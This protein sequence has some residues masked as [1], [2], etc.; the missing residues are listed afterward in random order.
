MRWQPI[1][2]AISFV[3]N[4]MNT[5]QKIRQ[6]IIHGSNCT[7]SSPINIQWTSTSNDYT[8]TLTSYI[9]KDEKFKD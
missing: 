1:K 2:D 7:F 6:E 4:L 5:T 9:D 8:I 3:K